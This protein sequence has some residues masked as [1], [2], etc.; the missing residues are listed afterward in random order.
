MP[1]EVHLLSGPSEL[2]PV[3]YYTIATHCTHKEFCFLPEPLEKNGPKQPHKTNI[4]PAQTKYILGTSYS[5][6]P[7]QFQLI[8]DYAGE[9]H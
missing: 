3:A 4:S 2:Q 6:E 8:L 5:C 9:W 1:K 7:K